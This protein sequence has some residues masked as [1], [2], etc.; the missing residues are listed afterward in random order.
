MT[1]AAPSRSHRA[2]TVFLGVAAVIVAMIGL[3]QFASI[4]APAFLALNLM[5]VVWPLMSVLKRFLPKI[6]ASII[7]GLA[8]ITILGLFFWSLG[9]A[10]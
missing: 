9:W 5:I 4:V 2:L 10:G 1:E 3:K 6:V 7:T 8:A